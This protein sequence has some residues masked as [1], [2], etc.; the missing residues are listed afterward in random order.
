[1]EKLSVP[2]LFWLDAHYSAGVTAR[3][4]VDTPLLAELGHILAGRDLGHV[5]VIDDARALGRDPAYPTIDELRD[6]ILAR[7]R[8]VQISVEGDSVRVIP[9]PTQT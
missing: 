3:G 9:S 7:R 1:M 6:F 8:N 4:E 2:A 5:I